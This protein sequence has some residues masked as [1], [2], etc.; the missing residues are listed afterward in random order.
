MRDKAQHG[1][2]GRVLAGAHAQLTDRGVGDLELDG[3]D[4]VGVAHQR[5]LVGGRTRGDGEHRG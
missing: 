4:V 3:G 5:A 1:T 2:V